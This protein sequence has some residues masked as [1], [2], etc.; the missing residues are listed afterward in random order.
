MS[1]RSRARSV[2]RVGARAVCVRQIDVCV[3]RLDLRSQN[4][5]NNFFFSERF[6]SLLL[7][8]VLA[9]LETVTFFP[10]GIVRPAYVL[11]R[12]PPAMVC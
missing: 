2:G 6:C 4:R 9:L 10:F 8:T 7:A 5:P 11:A 3:T 1:S 12:S